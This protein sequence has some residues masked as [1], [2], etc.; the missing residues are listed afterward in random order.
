MGFTILCSRGR[1]PH[2]NNNRKEPGRLDSFRWRTFPTLIGSVGFGSDNYLSRFDA[3]RPA[4]FGRVVASSGSVRF[5]SASGFS[6]FQNETVRFGSGRP[7]RFGFL[8]LPGDLLLLLLIIILVIIV[9]LLLLL[10]III[11]III[12]LIIILIVIINTKGALRDG[13]EA[14]PGGVR[15]ALSGERQS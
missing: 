11:M 4:F 9:L 15:P 3:L 14:H 12:I 13:L 10:L 8:L 6:R 1:I 2:G 7:L 5:V